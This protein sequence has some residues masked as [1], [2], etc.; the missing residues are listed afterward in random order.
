[1]STPCLGPV[2]SC[3]RAHLFLAVQIVA[4]GL[5]SEEL[6]I[7]TQC[8]RLGVTASTGDISVSCEQ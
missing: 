7:P 1:M 4:V 3:M 2:L 8:V 5:G 6:S